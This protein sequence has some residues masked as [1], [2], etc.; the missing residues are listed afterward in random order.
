M[1]GLVS[2]IVFN[3][4]SVNYIVA[5]SFIGGGNWEFLE[6]TTNLP[7]FMEGLYSAVKVSFIR[8]GN[9]QCTVLKCM[10]KLFIYVQGFE[11]RKRGSLPSLFPSF[12][13]N[14]HKI[15]ILKHCINIVFILQKSCINS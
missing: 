15:Y 14:T 1:E 10:Y 11:T 9:I 7:Q 4:I 13:A 2:F 8:R 6:K 5:V 12:V 3:N